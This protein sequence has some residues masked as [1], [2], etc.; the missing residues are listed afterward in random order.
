MSS[1]FK[2]QE[3]NPTWT[4]TA[5]YIPRSKKSSNTC[6]STFYNMLEPNPS[7]PTLKVFHQPSHT[8]ATSLTTFVCLHSSFFAGGQHHTLSILSR[9][10]SCGWGE[11]LVWWSLWWWRWCLF[12]LGH[13]VFW[14]W[15]IPTLYLHAHVFE[16]LPTLAHP[17][18]ACGYPLEGCGTWGRRSLPGGSGS[19][20]PILRFCSSLLLP[21][22]SLP[23]AERWK[24]AF[25][26][27]LQPNI[28]SVQHKPRN[29]HGRGIL[30]WENVSRRLP[31]GK[32]SP[33]L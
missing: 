31:A 13:A 23:S 27:F 18:P 5:Q 6:S 20:D 29:Y 3:T 1:T 28:L 7:I 10:T 32:A 30:N 4:D 9:T 26:T 16:P 24:A 17:R 25:L 21:A 33:R 11:F 14:M 2:K 22:S 19:L 15:H 12:C 8:P